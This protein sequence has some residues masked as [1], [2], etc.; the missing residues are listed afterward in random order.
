MAITVNPDGTVNDQAH[1]I[2]GSVAELEDAWRWLEAFQDGE[3]EAPAERALGVALRLVYREI[4]RGTAA[5]AAQARLAFLTATAPAI[6]YDR[7]AA[8]ETELERAA[9]RG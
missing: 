4:V 1:P 2:P 6:Y 7:P 3:W 5:E 8:P 9:A